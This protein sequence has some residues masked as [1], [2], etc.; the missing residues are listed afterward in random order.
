M[1]QISSEEGVS[2]KFSHHRSSLSPTDSL[3]D[4]DF[5]WSVFW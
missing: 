5:Q 3:G 1:N 4:I 2:H